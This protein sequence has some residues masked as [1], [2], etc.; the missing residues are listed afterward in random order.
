M[1]QHVSSLLAHPCNI[2]SPCLFLTPISPAFAFVYPSF[3]KKTQ[4]RNMQAHI[5]HAHTH[6]H[7][8]S[9]TTSTTTLFTTPVAVSFLP[10][11]HSLCRFTGWIERSWRK[12]INTWK[13]PLGNSSVSRRENNLVRPCERQKKKKMH[14]AVY[15]AQE[16]I[17]TLQSVHKF[18]THFTVSH[19]V[20]ECFMR[21]TSSEVHVLSSF[22]E[23]PTF[24]VFF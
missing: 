15:R 19:R 14:S 18:S 23:V 12:K 10:T 9:A 24:S 2:F 11:T 20:E 16:K 13:T 21:W 3:S 6:T 7:E 5:H 8:S 4:P 1:S 17:Y 22:T